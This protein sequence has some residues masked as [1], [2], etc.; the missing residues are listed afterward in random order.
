MA[1]W[2]PW[3]PGGQDWAGLG[4]SPEPQMVLLIL[5]LIALTASQAANNAQLIP[6]TTP[7]LSEDGFATVEHNQRMCCKL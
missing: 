6:K 3:L 1:S 5:S 2:G 7:S 4:P